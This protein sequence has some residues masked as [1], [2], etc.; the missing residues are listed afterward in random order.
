[1]EKVRLAVTITLLLMAE[2]TGYVWEGC[3]GGISE[4]LLYVTRDIP[5][6]KLDQ[7]YN[8]LSDRVEVPVQF[9]PTLATV[10]K[11]LMFV[12]NQE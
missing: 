12:F 9:F 7:L 4:V 3:V 6:E 5:S 2:D 11:T 1:M 10:N 8:L